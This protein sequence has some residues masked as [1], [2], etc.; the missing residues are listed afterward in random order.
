MRTPYEDHPM[1]PRR[2][3]FSL[4]QLLVAM[5][6]VALLL[7]S[8]RVVVNHLGPRNGLYYGTYRYLGP[9]WKWHEVRGAVIFVKDGMIFV[10]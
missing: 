2:I 8:A 4:R 9:D 1:R 6:I 3:R 7:A 10:D 5:A